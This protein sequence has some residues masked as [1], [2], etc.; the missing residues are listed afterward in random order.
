[1]RGR[2]CGL[3]YLKLP[4]H[5]LHRRSIGEEVQGPGVGV[6]VRVGVK[7]KVGVKVRVRVYIG[8]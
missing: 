1:M 5:G 2:E 6:K 8:R 4:L 7:V 3:S